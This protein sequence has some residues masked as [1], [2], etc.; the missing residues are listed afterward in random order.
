MRMMV[1]TLGVYVLFAW[2]D[3]LHATGHPVTSW[4]WLFLVTWAF[5]GAAV[6][7]AHAVRWALW[8]YNAGV[9]GS[10]TGIPARPPAV[11]RKEQP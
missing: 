8:K 7:I 4:W 2:E 3:V 9:A 1:W 11:I 6:G 10:A 5:L